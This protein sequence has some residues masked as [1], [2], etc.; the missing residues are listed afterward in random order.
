MVQDGR[1]RLRLDLPA[2]TQRRSHLCLKK[3]PKARGL[4]D[5]RDPPR[6]ESLGPSCETGLQGSNAGS[7]GSLC[8][9]IGVEP[10][11]GRHRSGFANVNA[12]TG[13][14]PGHPCRLEQPVRRPHGV[15]VYPQLRSQIPDGRQAGPRP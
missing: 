8:G 10:V 15:A 1:E 14:G 5:D 2:R 13:G 6:S 12:A 4:F 11:I 3:I 7:R 9:Q